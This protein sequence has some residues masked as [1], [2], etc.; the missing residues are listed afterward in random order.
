MPLQKPWFLRGFWG[1]MPQ[2]LSTARVFEGVPPPLSKVLQKRGLRPLF[3][4]PTN[5]SGSQTGRIWG[6]NGD[7]TGPVRVPYGSRTAPYGLYGPIWV[8]Y[9]PHMGTKVKISGGL[10]SG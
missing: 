8:P 10:G 4:S 3:N 2:S 6:P 7:H 1:I 5:Q 9:A